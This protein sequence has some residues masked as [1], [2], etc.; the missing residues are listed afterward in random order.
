MDQLL[1]LI[2]APVVVYLIEKIIDKWLKQRVNY[3]SG[4]DLKL[5]NWTKKED[6][7]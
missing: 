3:L 4:D 7:L 5:K 1:T 6:L 2:I